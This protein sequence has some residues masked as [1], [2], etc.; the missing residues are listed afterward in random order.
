MF[1]DVHLVHLLVAI[2]LSNR[3][4]F[5]SADFTLG[6]GF[7]MWFWSS[8]EA[9]LYFDSIDIALFVSSSVSLHNFDGCTL[10][11]GMAFSIPICFIMSQS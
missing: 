1:E 6:W 7:G 5:Y 11:L 10:S 3:L 4:A 9:H 8:V 2:L